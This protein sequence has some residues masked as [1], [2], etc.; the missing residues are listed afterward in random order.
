M[1]TLPG[2]EKVIATSRFSHH[3]M[4]PHKVTFASVGAKQLTGTASEVAYSASLDVNALK[5]MRRPSNN[6]P[7]KLPTQRAARQLVSPVT[8]KFVRHKQIFFMPLETMFQVEIFRKCCFVC[9]KDE[10][11]YTCFLSVQF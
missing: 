6:R 8:S 1:I 4:L 2:Q 10:T 11:C 3:L 9:L 5:E 7:A